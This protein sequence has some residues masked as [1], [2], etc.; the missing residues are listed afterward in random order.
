MKKFFKEHGFGL[1]E[2]MIAAGMA[3]ALALVVA[4]QGKE[5]NR[6]SK[7]TETNVEVNAFIQDVAYILSDKANCNETIP[8]GTTFP[9]SI[10][11]ISRI[12]SGAPVVVYTAGETYGNNTFTFNSMTV[13]KDAVT[14]EVY[15]DLVMEREHGFSYGAKQL[16]K[17]IPLQTVLDGTGTSIISCFS[18]VEAIITSAVQQSCT[19]N[20]A[21][22]DPVTKECVHNVQT[23]PCGANQ[24]LRRI[25]GVG[26][27]IVQ[28]C[29]TVMPSNTVCGNGEYVKA[30][31]LDGNVTCA[32]VAVS[33]AACNNGQYAIHISNGQVQCRDI[34][35]CGPQ[36]LLRSNSTTGALYCSLVTC[37]SANQ[38]FAG[39]DGVGSPVC[40]NFPDRTCGQGQYISE[41]KPDGSTI[42]GQVPN[43]Q[44]LPVIDYAFVDGFN[45]G[46]NTWSRK[47]LDQTAEQICA[48]LPFFTWA[49]GNCNA[50][51]SF[52]VWEVIQP[53]QYQKK[54][55]YTANSAGDKF[56]SID[57][58]ASMVINKGEVRIKPSASYNPDIVLND[59]SVTSRYYY[60]QSMTLEK[61]DTSSNNSMLRLRNND[62]G[63][64]FMEIMIGGDYN[65]PSRT[66]EIGLNRVAGTNEMEKHMLFL[67]N[68]GPSI[69][70]NRMFVPIPTNIY[71]Q[72]LQYPGLGSS[73]RRWANIYLSSSPNVSSDRRL[74]EDIMASNLGLDFLNDLKPVK[75]KYKDKLSHNSDI[76][77]GV[78]AQDTRDALKKYTNEKTE[79]VTEDEKGFLGVS[80]TALIAPIIAAIQELDQ[81]L[82][83]H[84]ERAA[85]IEKR[86][87]LLE[88]RIEALERENQQLKAQRNE[89]LD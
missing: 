43:H 46:T 32:P 85:A 39:F 54:I 47:S 87:E 15:V 81:K 69:G 62:G 37:N 74:K 19:G 53:N 58:N 9:S 8:T 68:S 84:N 49:G 25:E 71:G 4:Q 10:T 7:T 59:G 73:A 82:F 64:T 34:P 48:K 36:E 65:T 79:I 16:T 6:I 30:I 26:G 22:Y 38:Y 31:D 56:V 5:M 51:A 18:D 14:N 23:S 21:R 44:S 17:R 75:F 83:G 57:Q 42:C 29:T 80:Y 78:I 20:S 88:V 76:R 3:A 70:A 27:E 89:R 12:V 52:S 24:I 67:Q 86:L 61:S 33:N 60:G 66:A 28:V 11:N 55:Q 77:Y 2:V 63:D 40:K 35:K 13:D 41:V 45:A 72:G 1:V 50:P